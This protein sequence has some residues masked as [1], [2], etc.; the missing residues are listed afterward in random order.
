VVAASYL[1]GVRE[2]IGIIEQRGAAV[3]LGGVY[4]NSMYSQV[5]TQVLHEVHQT[6]LAWGIPVFD[7]L[8]TTEDPLAPGKWIPGISADAG[9][10]NTEGQALMYNAIDVS[11][12]KRVPC[13][14]L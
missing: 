13:P 7:F 6:M 8:S 12:F 9:H 5:H 1:D 11:L 3:F 14:L 10:P 2:L 4:P